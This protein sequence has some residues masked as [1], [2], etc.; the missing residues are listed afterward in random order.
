MRTIALLAL[1]I[2]GPSQLVFADMI[3]DFGGQYV[4]PPSQPMRGNSPLGIANGIDLEGDSAFNDAIGGAVF[5]TATPLS[6]TSNYSGKS[7]TFYGGA[8]LGQINTVGPVSFDEFDI[9]NQGPHDS[10]HLHGQG[11]G[12]I[13]DLHAVFLWKQEDFLNGGNPLVFDGNSFVRLKIGSTN[14]EDM[15]TA[16]FRV[17]VRDD[18]NKYWLS[19]AFFTNMGANSVLQWD[20]SNQGFSASSDGNW[21]SFDPDSIFP[22]LG[23]TFTGTDLRFTQVGASYSPK[24]FSSVTAVGFYLDQDQF[25]N[26]LDFHF[27]TFQVNANSVPEPATLVHLS[28]LGIAVASRFRRKNKSKTNEQ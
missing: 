22:G 26:N 17:I 5:T 11:N 10:P 3:V 6:P 7:S 20:N 15:S 1:L 23:P 27:E 28:L 12:D 13:H 8:I 14:T 9:K 21:A 16:Q 18:L 19:Q 25:H 4:T 24:K 2:L